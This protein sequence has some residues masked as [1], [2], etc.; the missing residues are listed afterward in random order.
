[1]RRIGG[2][3]SSA[4]SIVESLARTLAIGG[5]CLQV[6]AGS[7]RTWARKIWDKRVTDEFVL[8]VQS[9]DLFP[10]FIHALYLVN[11]GSDNPE[12][13]KK[14]VESLVFDLKN[15]LACQAAGVIVHLGSYQTRS[16]AEAKDSLVARIQEILSLTE[17]TPFVIENTSGQKGKIG[18]LEEIAEIFEALPDTRLKLC[19]DSAHLFEAGWDLRQAGELD[20]LVTELDRLGILKH[21]AVIHLNDSKTP[22]SSHRDQHANLGEGE[23]GLEGLGN[24]INHPQ[25]VH[26]PLILEVPGVDKQGP[27]LVNLDIAR[28]LAGRV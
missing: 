4:G 7:P 21:L 9:E 19:L 12:L 3:V 28:K 18:T 1:M 23:I 2:H 6:F 14:S 17:A 5:N 11:L 13:V 25:L 27:D 26:L 20:R 22:L 10:L 24:F 16:F 15:G 8:R